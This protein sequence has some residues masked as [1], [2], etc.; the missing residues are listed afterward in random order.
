M[1]LKYFNLKRE[2]FN[3][4][5]DPE[6]LFLSPS[7]KEALA[8]V[9]CGVNR[10]KGF[11][12]IIGEVGVGKTTI[13]RSFLERINSL[14]SIDKLNVKTIY[15][16]NANISFKPL[17]KTIYQNLGCV[18]EADDVCS[19][20]DQLHQILIDEYKA[21]RNVVLIIDEAQN[22]PIETLENLRMLSNLESSTDKLIQV[23]LTGQPEFEQ[24]LNQHALRQLKQRIAIRVRILPL[25]RSESFEYINHRL[26]RTI[27]HEPE[28]FSRG[29]LSRIVREA[30]GIP[31]NINI[32][33]DNCLVTSFGNQEKIVTSKVAK[34][35]ISDFRMVSHVTPRWK[36]PVLIGLL[37]AVSVVWLIGNMNHILP[38]PEQAKTAV[39]TNGNAGHESTVQVVQAAPLEI[40]E[41]KRIET[42]TG[43]KHVE[44]VALA[45]R[46]VKKGDTLAWLILQRYG[47]IDKDLLNMVVKN[48]PQIANVNKIQEGEKIYFPE[49]DKLVAG[50]VNTRTRQTGE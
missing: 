25:S 8:A 21:G 43:E 23:I 41:Q 46:V 47:S 38:A 6:L 30:E 24:K 45:H 50:G 28:I 40:E 14:G 44:K 7:H 17:L 15:I 39:I 37:V 36:M 42:D 35:I 26:S 27:I 3:I 10:R 5:P 12:A 31:R 13:I 18:P 1:Y 11:V 9:I 4:T 16:F 19:M 48:N 49:R 34:E 20:V 22:M 32:L 33:C 29:A 2:P